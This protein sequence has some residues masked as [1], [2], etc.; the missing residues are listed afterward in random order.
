MLDSYIV[1]PLTA[2]DY[3]TL[4]WNQLGAV[5]LDTIQPKKSPSILRAKR[6][7]PVE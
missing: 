3:I 7:P 1:L 2:F 4:G 5:G 6:Y